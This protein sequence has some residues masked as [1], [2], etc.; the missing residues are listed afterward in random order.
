[1]SFEERQYQVYLSAKLKDRRNKKWAMSM[2]LI[3][4]IEMLKK[5]ERLDTYIPKPRLAEWELEDLQLNL[6]MALNSNLELKFKMWCNGNFNYYCGL[7]TNIDTSNRI[8]YYTDSLNES[9]GPFAI[10]DIVHI[11]VV[12]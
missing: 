10:D 1:M 7:I 8:F 9:H 2:M 12:D 5:Q 3:E 4:H 11:Q 6:T